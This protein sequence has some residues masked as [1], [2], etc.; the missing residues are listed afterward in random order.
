MPSQT[1][2]LKTITRVLPSDGFLAEAIGLPEVSALNDVEHKWREA[3][4]SKAE[5]ILA[6]PALAPTES[7]HCRRSPGKIELEVVEMTFEPPRRAADWQHPVIVPIHFARWEEEGMHHAF[8]PVLGLRVFASRPELLPSRV[9]QHVRLVLSARR[10]RL[11]LETLAQLSWVERLEIGELTVTV[12]RKSPRQ[13]IAEAEAQGKPE[14]ALLTLAEEL[15]PTLTTLTGG[16]EDKPAGRKAGGRAGAP[17]TPAYELEQELAQLAEALTGQ[18]RRSILLVGPPGCG[19]TALVR[20]LARRRRAFGFGHTPFWTTSAARLMTGPIGFGMW[21]SRCQELCR[22]ASKTQAILHLGNLSDLL[23]VGKASRSEQSIGGFLRPWIARGDVLAIAECHPDQLGAIERRDPHLLGAFQHV[24]LPE[25]TPEQTLRILELTVGNAQGKAH[26][27]APETSAALRRLQ[28]LH[29]RYATYSANPGRPLRFLNNL[30]ADRF[31]EISL[32]EVQVIA[33]FSRETGLPRLLLDEDLPLDLAAAQRWFTERVVGQPAAVGHVLDLLATAKAGLGRPRKPLASLLFIGPTGTGK[34]EM[35][36]ALAEFLFGDIGRLARFDLN[37]FSDP[38]SVQ[39]LIGGPAAGQPE[40]LLTARAREQPFSVILLD[41]FEKADPSFFDLLLQVLGDGRLTDAAGRVADFCNTVIVMTSNLGVQEFQRGA[42]GFRRGRPGAEERETDAHFADAVRRF[43][44]PEIFNRLDAIVPFRG[45][46]REMVLTIARRHLDRVL[47]RDGLRLRGVDCAIQPTVAEWLADR[48]YDPRYGARPLK[49]A[50]EQDFLL[51]LAEA[52]NQYLAETPL[53]AEMAVTDRRLRIEVRARQDAKPTTAAPVTERGAGHAGDAE[54]QPATAAGLARTITELR[55]RI[56]ALR[57]CPAV[58]RLEDDLTLLEFHRRRAMRS[59][60]PSWSP[61][62]GR[63]TELRSCLEDLTAV[64]RRVRD[65]ETDVLTAVYRREEPDRAAVLS[66]RREIEQER[67]RL[68]RQVYRLNQESP[69]EI[70]LAFHGEPHELAMEFATLHVR[71][72][73][74]HGEVAAVDYFRLGTEGRGDA[75]VLVRESA[76]KPSEF[77]RD[78][79]EKVI[80][81][82]LRLT[83]ELIGPR[84]ALESGRHVKEEKKREPCCLVQ[85]VHG[86]M[87]D[88]QPRPELLRPGAIRSLGE[89]TIRKYSWG[90]AWLEDAQLGRREWSGM[91]LHHVLEEVMEERLRR[92]IELIAP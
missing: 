39:R 28:R 5:I 46:T 81:V 21:Q 38:V 71:V 92:A 67:R 24:L 54:A 83:G 40:G 17:S 84:F 86:P 29:A 50:I 53:R 26:N 59:R 2:H 42:L 48:G 47:Q 82:L 33:A 10:K 52:L 37:E 55:R 36:K 72:A 51:P 15:P 20:E 80:A 18:H 62:D 45:L 43:L 89:P 19:K 68:M 35:A 16:P 73:E 57:R 8:V 11:T 58:S 25:R 3:L 63:M 7:L 60:R 49:R 12:K 14:S 61:Q 1:F 65:L 34:T 6:D 32:T 91:A 87:A 90:G 23:E 74:R 88:Y 31:P 66:P 76:P 4:Q 44:R 56:S 77:F 13:V 9:E 27:A 69:D 30:L 70:V 85:V 64:G 22:E 79:P 75:P 78:P 41:E